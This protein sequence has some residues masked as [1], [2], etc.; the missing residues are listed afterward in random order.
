MDIRARLMLKRGRGPSLEQQNEMI[1]KEE[2][3][4]G[5]DYIHPTKGRRR[6]SEKRVRAIQ[7]L[8]GLLPNPIKK[9]YM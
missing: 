7:H 8:A 1:A 2:G 9:E 5:L 4:N 6:I 3:M